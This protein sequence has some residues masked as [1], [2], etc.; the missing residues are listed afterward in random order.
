MIL[1]N[2]ISVLIPAAGLGQ[3]SGLSYPKS[4]YK[5]NQVPIIIRIL[6]KIIKYDKSPSLVINSKHKDLFRETLRKYFFSKYELLYQNNPTG[7]GDAV[8]KFKKSKFYQKTDHILLIWGDLP[9]LRK[10]NI[11]KLIHYHLSN[12][13]FMTILSSFCKEPYTLIRKDY[14]NCVKEILESKNSKKQFK[15]GERD[16]GVFIFKKSLLNYLKNSNKKKEHNFLYVIN[17]IYKKRFIIK[18]LPIAS[19]RETISLNYISDLK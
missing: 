15:F 3:R 10:K 2:K 16:I 6:K 8:K 14:K 12:S 19:F 17:T 11:D 7:M 18:S 4:L 9:N 13:N 1:K 5:V